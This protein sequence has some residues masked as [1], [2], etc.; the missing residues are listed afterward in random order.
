M[1]KQEKGGVEKCSWN[2]MVEIGTGKVSNV[3]DRSLSLGFLY[4]YMYIEVRT[5]GVYYV[6]V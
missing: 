5:G 3:I 1:F 2:L 4:I 6:Y